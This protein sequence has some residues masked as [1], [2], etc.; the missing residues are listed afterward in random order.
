MPQDDPQDEAASL[1]T[2]EESLRALAQELESNLA[3]QGWRI[4][5][6]RFGRN[7][8]DPGPLHFLFSNPLSGDYAYG[9]GRKQRVLAPLRAE[10]TETIATEREFS[11]VRRAPGTVAHPE[12]LAS[13]RSIAFAYRWTPPIIDQVAEALVNGR[14][15]DLDEA[16]WL[17]VAGP[18]VWGPSLD[19]VDERWRE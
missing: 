13:L 17:T 6:E 9:I 4:T 16:V 7:A 8:S 19:W 5:V 1:A 18:V 10:L 3:S 2:Y 14:A 11:V 12:L 15:L